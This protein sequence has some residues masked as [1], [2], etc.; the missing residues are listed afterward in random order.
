MSEIIHKI[1]VIETSKKDS[2]LLH[3]SYDII[4]QEGLD[5]PILKKEIV[6]EILVVNN[7]VNYYLDS[8]NESTIVFESSRGFSWW[9]KKLNDCFLEKMDFQLTKVTSNP[10]KAGTRYFYANSKPKQGN[11]DSFYENCVNPVKNDIDEEE[12]ATTKCP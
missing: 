2:Y 11:T 10:N 1:P 6:W 3:L 4:E 9:L 8:P 12:N 7:G 5:N